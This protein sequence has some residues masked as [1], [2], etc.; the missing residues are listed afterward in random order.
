[1]KRG[2]FNYP[3]SQGVHAT[4]TAKLAV[5]N[6]TI[7]FVYARTKKKTTSGTN[8]LTRMVQFWEDVL[9][10]VKMTNLVKQFALLNSS[11]ISKSVH[12]K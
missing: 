2:Q 3:Y 5:R 12:V 4:L 9:T 11:K 6:V 8:V 10:I 7:L 1:M